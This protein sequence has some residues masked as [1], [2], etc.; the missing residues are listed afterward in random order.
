VDKLRAVI[1]KHVKRPASGRRE[2]HHG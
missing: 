2:E 1:K